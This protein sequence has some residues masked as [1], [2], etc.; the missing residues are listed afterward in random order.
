MGS[1]YKERSTNMSSPT[2]KTFQLNLKDASCSDHDNIASSGSDI[3]S[4][5]KPHGMPSGRIP[6]QVK[7]N[8]SYSYD[9]STSG[10]TWERKAAVPQAD[11][12]NKS[13]GGLETNS[14][15]KPLRQ[16]P[17]IREQPVNGNTQ[18]P[19][20]SP[21]GKKRSDFNR[22]AK[23]KIRKGNT[24]NHESYIFIAILVTVFFNPPIGLISLC[25]SVA[26]RKEYQYGDRKRGERLANISLV[27]SMTGLVLSIV[28]IIICVFHM[29]HLQQQDQL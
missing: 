14:E 6:V 4:I 12:S 21:T 11:M 28:V 19:Q 15:I 3:Q 29:A 23:R 24:R 8:N 22:S 10:P 5:P 17:V 25:I 16:S 7:L 1:A 2:R 9:S 27:V 13:P 18:H 20:L 26:S